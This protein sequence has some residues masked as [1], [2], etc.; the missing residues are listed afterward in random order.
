M[1]RI[2]KSDL[3]TM[4]TAKRFWESRG[5]A[6]C[7]VCPMSSANNRV[8][9]TCPEFIKFLGGKNIRDEAAMKGYNSQ[10]RAIEYMIKYS[11]STRGIK[12]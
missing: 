10:H 8:G 7:R 12:I 11:N 6:D 5:L 2:S 3:A 1:K 4:K 9:L